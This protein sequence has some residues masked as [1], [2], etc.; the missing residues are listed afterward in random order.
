MLTPEKQIPRNRKPEPPLPPG[1]RNLETLR[2]AR[3]LAAKLVSDSVEMIRDACTALM[4]DDCPPKRRREALREIAAEVDWLGST[5]RRPLGF[6]SICE[7]LRLNG[8]LIRRQMAAELNTVPG[9]GMREFVDR[10]NG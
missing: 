2:G 9:A 4:S 10:L 8:A 7:S 1:E 5:D 6:V 3:G